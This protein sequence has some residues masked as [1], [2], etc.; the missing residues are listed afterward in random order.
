MKNFK[1]NIEKTAYN[2]ILDHSNQ[3][4]EKYVEGT[5]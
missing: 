4:D 5:T 3:N 1:V 2:F